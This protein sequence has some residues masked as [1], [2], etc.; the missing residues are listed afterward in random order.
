MAVRNK[1]ISEALHSAFARCTK[2]SPIVAQI[3]GLDV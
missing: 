1:I 3:E 2:A